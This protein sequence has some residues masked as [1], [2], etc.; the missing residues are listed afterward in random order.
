MK[1]W[2]IDCEEGDLVHSPLPW[3]KRG[4]S[5]TPTGYGA[6]IPTSWKAPYNGKLYR[7]YATCFSNAGSLWI[8]SKGE[9]LYIRS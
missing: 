4:L 5:P 3:Q 7:V 8:Q 1:A 2:Y 6:R 9:K